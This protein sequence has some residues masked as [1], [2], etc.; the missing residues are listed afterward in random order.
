MLAISTLCGLLNGVV[1]SYMGTAAM[2]TTLG[3]SILY[4]GIGLLISKGNSI[5]KFPS[6]FYWFGNST[7]LGIPIPMYLFVFFAL[8]VHILLHRTPWGLNVYMI[9]SNPKASKFSGINVE[10]TTMLAYT[11]SGLLS[12]VAAVIMMSRYNSA[13]IDYG[14]SYLMQTVAASVLGGTMIT[15][16]YG[17]VYGVVL[18]VA[19]LQCLSS[20]LNIFGL[21][22]SLTSMITGAVLIG[23]LAVG[24]FASHRNERV[25]TLKTKS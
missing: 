19:T 16:G 12:G 22:T 20:G 15:G 10:G 21:D 7:F 18:A 2:M 8:L 5:S 13:R 25:R 4:E 6:E 3:T 17:T 24:F 23:T 14:S 11:L 9:G 1:V